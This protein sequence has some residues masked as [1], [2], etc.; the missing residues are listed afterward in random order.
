VEAF[1]DGDL[2]CGNCGELLSLAPLKELILFKDSCWVT[3]SSTL[4]RNVSSNNR[5]PGTSFNGEAGRTFANEEG[6]DPSRVGSGQNALVDGP[7]DF[8]TVIGFRDNNTG[9]A[10]DL[11]KAAQSVHQRS[12]EKTLNA[13]FAEIQSMCE[14]I[15]LPRGVGDIA[16]Q[17]YKRAN[18]EGVLRGKPLDASAAACIFIACRQGRVA[19]TFK[20]IAAQTQV[21]KTAIAAC[22]KVLR[23][24][25]EGTG[26]SSFTGTEAGSMVAPGQ[27]LSAGQ[28]AA[29]AED[30]I[31]RFASNL[32]L[33]PNVQSAARLVAN[34]VTNAGHLTGRNPITVASAVLFFTA[35]LLDTPVTIQDVAKVGGMAESTIKHAYRL[36]PF[37]GAC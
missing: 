13:A 10:K 11:K 3:E 26:V 17:L 7:E 1:G 15:G 32:A 31:N 16:K 28:I 33:P 29:S 12:G 20:E 22:F 34:K 5:T 14:T 36:V 25:F 23:L 18:E 8:S 35:H 6:D 19:R 30:L 21:N 2:V 4:D 9:V 27:E 24:K 37:L